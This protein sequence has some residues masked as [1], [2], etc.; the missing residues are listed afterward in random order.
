MEM[1]FRAQDTLR[2]FRV[3]DVDQQGGQFPHH[4]VTGD[5]TEWFPTSWRVL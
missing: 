2:N 5:E 1:F 3:S 4:A